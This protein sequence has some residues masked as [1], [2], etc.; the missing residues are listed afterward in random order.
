M[1]YGIHL[2]I[3]NAYLPYLLGTTPPLILI[4]KVRKSSTPYTYSTGNTLRRQ[5]LSSARETDTPSPNKRVRLT[6]L[7]GASLNSSSESPG[8]A[9]FPYKGTYFFR[10]G[11]LRIGTCAKHALPLGGV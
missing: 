5:A 3:L 4:S 8:F 10:L 11:L 2:H 6:P 9:L 7:L 1:S